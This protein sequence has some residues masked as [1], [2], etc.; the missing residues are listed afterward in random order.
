LDFADILLHVR[1]L[2]SQSVSLP[3]GGLIEDIM[4]EVIRKIEFDDWNGLIA[5]DESIGGVFVHCACMKDV[6]DGGFRDVSCV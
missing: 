6:G 5:I 3:F 2:S 4:I 1:R